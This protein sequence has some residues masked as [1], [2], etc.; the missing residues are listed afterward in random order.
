[1]RR[2]EEA[3]SF[4]CRKH[5]FASRRK[6]AGIIP[7]SDE[8]LV[9]PHKLNAGEILYCRY[10][11]TEYAVIKHLEIETGVREDILEKDYYLTLLL[12]EPDI[13][14]AYS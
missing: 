12:S 14:R 8:D 7:G 4:L 1:M 3:S 9:L 5:L 6:P 2:N 10:R 11:Y 13:S